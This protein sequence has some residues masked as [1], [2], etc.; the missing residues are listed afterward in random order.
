MP[1]RGTLFFQTFCFAYL[2][3]DV[4][5][6]VLGE[7]GDSL[8]FLSSEIGKGA[9]RRPFAATATRRSTKS[10]ASALISEA[11]SGIQ[12]VGR[13]TRSGACCLPAMSRCPQASHRC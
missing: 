3:F 5:D 2:F 12:R 11:T 8:E 6:A 4:V 13:G 10:S 7:S 1:D 9:S